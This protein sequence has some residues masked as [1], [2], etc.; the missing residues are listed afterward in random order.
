MPLASFPDSTP[1]TTFSPPSPML[2]Q[3]EQL[4]SVFQL[5]LISSYLQA[6]SKLLKKYLLIYFFDTLL[7]T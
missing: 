7:E 3:Y 4:I 1:S 2:Q 6:F 5:S